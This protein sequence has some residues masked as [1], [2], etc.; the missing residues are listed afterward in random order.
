MPQ[1][2]HEVVAVQWYKRALEDWHGAQVLAKDDADSPNSVWL[3]Q[4]AVEKALKSLLFLNQIPFKKTHDLETLR[5][6]LPAA[7]LLKLYPV[8]SMY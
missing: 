7:Y 1:P 3:I 5:S 2:E 4:Q 8:T 6:L